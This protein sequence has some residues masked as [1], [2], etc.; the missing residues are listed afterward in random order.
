MSQSLNAL[1]PEFMNKYNR[2]HKYDQ[3]LS[4]EDYKRWCSKMAEV[5]KCNEKMEE[6]LE[7]ACEEPCQGYSLG[8]LGMLLLWFIIFTV[9]FWLIFYSLKPS[10]AL[11]SD[12]TVNTGK[13]LLAA[14]VSSIVLVIVIWLIK[15]CIDC[16]R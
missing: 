1:A 10:W 16:S 8:W 5:Q 11:N 13:V 4:P 2:T 12:G 15:S 7:P 14:I 3:K 9:L 6:C